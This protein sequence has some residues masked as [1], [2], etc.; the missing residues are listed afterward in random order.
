MTA[1]RKKSTRKKATAP[2]KVSWADTMKKALDSK[3]P[4]GGW[5]DQGKPR[6]SAVKKLRQ[7]AF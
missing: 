1:A 3:R 4:A 5:P 2:A 7:K 6:D